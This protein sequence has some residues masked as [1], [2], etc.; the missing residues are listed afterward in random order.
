MKILVVNHPE[1]SYA[2]EIVAAAIVRSF[3]PCQVGR[4]EYQSITGLPD[5]AV[6]LSPRAPDR[7]LLKKLASQGRK[8]LLLG[9]LDEKLA[10]DVALVSRPFNGVAGGSDIEI[11]PAEPFNTTSAAVIYNTAHPLGKASGLKKRHLCRF[12]F[13]D[14]WN[15]LG[16]GRIN[17]SGD[18]WSISNIADT[19]GAHAL[20]MIQEKDGLPLTVYA[21]V[22]DRPDSAILWYNRPV[23]PVDSLEWKVI[24]TFFGDYRQEELNC[25]PYLP[26]VPYGFDGAITMRLDCDQAV[27]SATPLFELYESAGVPFSLAV[28]T[29]LKMEGPDTK[30]LDEIIKSGGSVVSHSHNHHPNWG[31]GYQAAFYEA[32]ESKHW[33]EENTTAGVVRYAISPFHQNPAYAL[34]ALADAGYR[35]FI[36]GI[37]HNDPEFLLGR[38]GQVP[39]VKKKLISHSQQ[40]LL[41]GDCYHRYGNAIEVY[42]ESF[43]NHMASGSIF[44]YMD[45]PFSKEYS[46]GW[47]DEGER[48]GVHEE[49]LN[50]LLSPGKIWRCSINSCLDFLVMR[51]SARVFAENRKLESKYDK[52]SSLPPLAVRWRGDLFEG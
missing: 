44:G 16:Y 1:D 36:G 39:V 23:G 6:L 9:L 26:E 27:S 32:L 31:G 34:E 47:K 41:H 43:K 33:L 52:V 4:A 35:G 45:H 8:V 22:C 37:I 24:E 40:C 46:Y 5:A 25:F 10:D 38:A 18:I 14:E 48:I 7:P 29:G 12:D 11:N 17:T 21:A 49:L 13:T 19:R 30:L 15:N 42:K 20:A 3:T 2:G 50:F 28:L 51:D